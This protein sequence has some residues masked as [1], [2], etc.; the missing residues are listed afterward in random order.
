VDLLAEQVFTITEQPVHQS[1]PIQIEILQ[2]QAS[3]VK[4]VIVKVQQ[5]V[6]YVVQV[7]IVRLGQH[8]V[9][10]VQQELIQREL[11]QVARH[12]LLMQQ[13]AVQEPVSHVE[14]VIVRAQHLVQYVVSAHI[15]RLVQPLVQTAHLQLVQQG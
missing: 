15:V 1:L 14:Q 2:E 9:P 12:F 7:H 3:H 6:Q 4:Q 8:L 5:L 10:N 11:Q 13:L